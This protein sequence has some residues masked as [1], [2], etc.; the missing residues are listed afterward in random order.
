MLCVCTLL[1]PN[2][3]NSF[4]LISRTIKRL[5]SFP[6]MTHYVYTLL[7][8]TY[9]RNK[10]SCAQQSFHSCFTH[11]LHKRHLRTKIMPEVLIKRWT[12][13]AQKIKQEPEQLW[14][15]IYFVL[16]AFVQTQLDDT[17]K[18]IRLGTVIDQC[19]RYICF[20][21]IFCE[22]RW[23]INSGDQRIIQFDCSLI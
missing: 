13:Y 12:Y 3:L 2:A 5:N 1:C 14:E 23:P 11:T 7:I 10:L 16:I 22:Q 8:I 15:C 4:K 20:R 18:K 21:H 17:V 9:S 6:M 19:A